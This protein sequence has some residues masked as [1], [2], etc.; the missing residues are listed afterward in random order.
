MHTIF[1][2]TFFFIEKSEWNN[3]Q[4]KLEFMDHLFNNILLIGNYNIS[5]VYWDDEVENFIWSCPQLTPWLS[6]RDWA[7]K[8]FPI[9]Y[10][11]RGNSIVQIK[12]DR[13]LG[14]C[15]VNPKMN[16]IQNDLY[17]YFLKNIHFIIYKKE[18]I[19][20]CL[21]LKNSLNKEKFIFDC[22]CHTYKLIPSL[23]R[24]YTDWYSKIDKNNLFPKNGQEFK[25]INQH[26]EIIK[27]IEFNNKQ[28]LYDYEFSDGFKKDFINMN[29]DKYEI[30]KNITKRLVLTSNEAR[31]DAILKEEYLEQYKEYRFRINFKSRVHMRFLS[32]TEIEFL[33]YYGPGEHDKGL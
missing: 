16:I 30:L 13:T 19:I 2:P 32:D 20:L 6:N 9:F 33:H 25:R 5:K 15:N 18:Q 26:I 23:I 24:K 8:F 4:K 11:F 31:Q 7:N 29:E 28:L 10:K 21:G 22:N 12:F 14:K 3:E 17:E 1:D 27:I